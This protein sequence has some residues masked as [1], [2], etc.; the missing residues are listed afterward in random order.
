[1]RL[2]LSSAEIDRTV[3]IGGLL[4]KGTS[5][6]MSFALPP[7]PYDYAALEP[8]IDATTMN[9]HHTKH[10]NTY[11]TNVNN[12]LAGE[13]GSPIKVSLCRSRLWFLLFLAKSVYDY[14]VV[15]NRFACLGSL[16]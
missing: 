3:L 10:H 7:L 2:I 12:V 8:H 4:R 1:M 9:I 15:L 5:G 16:T 11:I 13:N 6:K 14:A